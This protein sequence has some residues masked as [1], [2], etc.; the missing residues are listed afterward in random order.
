V[1]RD[2]AGPA[3][4]ELESWA[5]EL[6]ARETEVQRRVR[7]ELEDRG[8]P[9]IQVPPRTGRFLEILVRATGARRI[10]EVGT[11]GGISAL[12]MARGLPSPQENSGGSASGP[13]IVTL[14]KEPEHARLAREAVE[15]AGEE[16]RI[17]IRVGDAADLLPELADGAWDLVFLDA[18]KESYPLYG[19]H[20][21]RLLRPGG[22]L[23]ADNAFW[24]GKI[25]DPEPGDDAT[26]ALVEFQEGLAAGSGFQATVVPV[27]DGV[28]V[29]VRD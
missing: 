21:R 28:L 13:R 11:L 5:E 7:E 23:V 10:V 9:L 17:E 4:D 19:R 15:R 2:G 26:R 22:L 24:H 27:G 6:F 8:L 18:D 20:A 29:A 16:D 1:S 3:R 12:W 25:L 14:E